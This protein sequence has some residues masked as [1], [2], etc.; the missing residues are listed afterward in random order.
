MEEVKID[1]QT[2]AGQRNFRRT[3]NRGNRGGA[4]NGG[5][6]GGG[7]QGGSNKTQRNRRRRQRQRARRSAGGQATG[8]RSNLQNS[9]RRLADDNA[10]DLADSVARV[11]QTRF[12]PSLGVFRGPNENGIAIPSNIGST[13]GSFS[14]T[15]GTTT[16][17]YLNFMFCPYNLAQGS[18]AITLPFCS[19][20]TA[21]AFTDPTGTGATGIAGPLNG[22]TSSYAQARLLSFELV[23]R[24]SSNLMKNNGI[25]QLAYFQ[26][27]I[28]NPF[29]DKAYFDNARFRKQWVAN[30]T[31]VLH[32]YPNAQDVN[33]QYQSNVWSD[34]SSCIAGYFKVAA[35]S[36]AVTM[37]FD[38]NLTFEFVAGNAI[39]IFT[40]P[41]EELVH[42][43]AEYVVAKSVM[44]NYDPLLI[45]T[46]QDYT[47]AKTIAQVR[48]GGHVPKFGSSNY[49]APQV[50]IGG[51]S[52]AGLR[53]DEG[54]DE[55][56]QYG[57]PYDQPKRS[58][59]KKIVDTVCDTIETGT[60]L[61]V[62]TDPMGAVGQ[63][64][65]SYVSSVLGLQGNPQLQAQRTISEASGR[66]QPQI[67]YRK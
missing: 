50:S 20:I 7:N 3:A 26:D 63:V 42:P 34:T 1:V 58:T 36:D 64:A 32:A 18:G 40:Y 62:C 23:I 30:E 16:A 47:A 54:Y 31:Y 52:G 17:D 45:G 53:G 37:V 67:Q 59:I 43:D 15:W 11:S 57:D 33:W 9:L 55:N 49:H 19:Y 66:S 56:Y 24:Q 13:H 48:T 35:S 38:Y 10:F 8:G 28:P 14:V 4:Q 44:T 12:Y 61:P 6:T 27:G 41:S 21:S 51:T 60:G 46:M 25:G 65:G 22:K 5:N 2:N 29:V 39:G